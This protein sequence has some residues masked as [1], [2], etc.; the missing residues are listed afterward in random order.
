MSTFSTWIWVGIGLAAVVRAQSADSWGSCHTRTV[1]EHLAGGQQIKCRSVQCCQYV[2]AM[3]WSLAISRS[4][5]S[6]LGLLFKV[7]KLTMMDSAR[8]D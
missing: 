8:A 2:N 3:A 7:W 1:P 6:H 5:P 4:C